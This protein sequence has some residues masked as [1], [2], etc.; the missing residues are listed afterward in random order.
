LLACGRY[1]GSSFLSLLAHSNDIV[2]RKTHSKFDLL[3]CAASLGMAALVTAFSEVPK[4]CPLL[5]CG[6]SGRPRRRF[7]HPAFLQRMERRPRR[8]APITGAPGNFLSA[9]SRTIS[10]NFAAPLSAFLHVPLISC[11][12]FSQITLQT[13]PCLEVFNSEC[14]FLPR[15]RSPLRPCPHIPAFP[16]VKS[17]TV[18]APPPF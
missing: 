9:S 5:D 1:V 8:L 6:G 11:F 3:L 7:F 12:V 15:C 16:D 10:R 13:A 17:Q 18:M 2:R 14:V 4:P